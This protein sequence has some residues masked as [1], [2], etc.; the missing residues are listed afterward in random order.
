MVVYP[1]KRLLRKL[2]SWYVG[3]FAAE[4]RSFNASVLRLHDELSVRTD[5]LVEEL[6]REAAARTSDRAGLRGSLEALESRTESRATAF[7]AETDQLGRALAESARLL[8]E[9]QARLLRLERRPAAA[10][11]T[12]GAPSPISA[13][14]DYFAFE[15]RMR[16]STDE[17]RI[18]QHDYVEDFRDCAPVLDVGCGRGEFLQLLRDGGIEARG[19][20]HDA[21]MVAFCRGEQLDV[22]EADA[23]AYLVALPDGELGGIFCAHVLEHFPPKPLL[24]LLDLARAKLRPDGLFVAETPNPRTLVALSTFFSDLTHAQPLHPETLSFLARQAGFRRVE[25][26]YLNEP[27]DEARLRHVPLLAEGE[28]E[29]AREALDANFDRLNEVVFGPQDYAVLCRA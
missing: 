9:L 27:P 28:L 15:A 23:T 16:G 22:E 2:M 25:V 8:E 4:Q 10:P 5:T 3:P 13:E 26:R 18:R 17:I 21:D 1:V 29:P 12:P 24:R 19:I 14:P 7:A 20:D 11:S 6:E